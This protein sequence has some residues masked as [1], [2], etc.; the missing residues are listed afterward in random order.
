MHNLEERITL[1]ESSVK[2]ISQSI[3]DISCEVKKIQ[4][5]GFDKKADIKTLQVSYDFLLTKIEDVSK[6]VHSLDE[7]FMQLISSIEKKYDNLS[8]SALK[9]TDLIPLFV[10]V[11]VLFSIIQFIISIAT[12]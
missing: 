3:N 7:R 2:N 6:V 9:K 4:Q 12:K 8:N 5:N 11:S 10:G 1:L